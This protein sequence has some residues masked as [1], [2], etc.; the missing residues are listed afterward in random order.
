MRKRTDKG[1]FGGTL[2]IPAVITLGADA[3]V[4]RARNGR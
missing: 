4:C 2:I 3:I 1:P